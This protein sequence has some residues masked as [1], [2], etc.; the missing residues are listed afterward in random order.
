[1]KTFRL[2]NK[3]SCGADQPDRADGIG[4]SR[5]IILS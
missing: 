3:D 4:N 1:M 5:R 2:T